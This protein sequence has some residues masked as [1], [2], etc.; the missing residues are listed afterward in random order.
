MKKLL[1]TLLT[2]AML[3]GCAAAPVQTVPATSA[4]TESTAAQWQLE[5]GGLTISAPDG[6][7]ENAITSEEAKDHTVVRISAPGTY[8]LSGKLDA[9][10]IAVDL[11][12]KAREDPNAVVT[13]IL[14][15]LDI[16]CP[17]APAI[18]FY[19]VWESGEPGGTAGANVILAEGSVNYVN[20]SHTEDDD[21]ALYSKMSMTLGGEGALLITGDNEGLCSEMHLTVSSGDI[22]IRS[23][24]DGINTNAD[25]VSVTTINGGHLRITVTGQTG[26]GD[27]IDS[28]GSIVIGGGVVEAFAC[29]S[30]MDSGIDADL[31][32]R[33]SG[34]IV[35]ATGNMLDQI[36]ENSQT[37][38][39]FSFAQPQTGGSYT[40]KNEQ[41]D[42]LF[43]ITVPNGF[44]SLI[45]STS[46]LT[47]GNYTLWS[48]DIQFEGV[49]GGIGHGDRPQFPGR[50]D[51]RVEIPPQPT[52]PIVTHGEQPTPDMSVQGEV[53]FIPEMPAGDPP[54]D[55]PVPQFPEGSNGQM[56]V[57]PMPQ[58][59]ENMP[60]P[61]LPEGVEPPPDG[62]GRQPIGSV[63]IGVLSTD[64]PITSGANYFTDLRPVE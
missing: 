36:D 3:C 61:Q 17:S 20:G 1:C 21:G 8:I 19:N 9:G 54:A 18:V 48:G 50:D 56:P 52:V 31:G 38:A 35:V 49:S 25:G 11:G 44:S 5:K 60:M 2:A 55:M 4:P 62:F 57:P 59:G 64:F 39:V 28:N 14:D 32:I 34:G 46:D 45:F 16:T 47:E 58:E 63:V 41:G 7:S 33:I 24:N 51:G 43:D 29:G 15:G 12:E 10:Q 37:H 42:V 13:L 40:L 27:G 53:P 30:S 26:E 6:L 23:G 22:F